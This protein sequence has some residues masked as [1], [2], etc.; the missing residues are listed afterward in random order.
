MAALGTPLEICGV[1]A[2]NFMPV[3]LNT[4]N[5]SIRS[6][7]N[8]TEKDKIAL[9]SVQLSTAAIMLQ[10]AV[11]MEFGDSNSAKLDPLTVSMSH[12]DA[13]ATVRVSR[14]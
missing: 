7:K 1:S 3:Y 6:L 9:P 14:W 12:P 13:V 2:T 4:P 11:A 10:V 8:F 5:P